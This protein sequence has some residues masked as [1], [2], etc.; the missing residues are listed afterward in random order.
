MERPA[1]PAIE[2][3]FAARQVRC[4]VTRGGRAWVHHRRT[5]S[6][7]AMVGRTA[8]AASCA[9]SARELA[10]R[11]RCASANPAAGVRRAVASATQRVRSFR[12]RTG[13]R[14]III[15]YTARALGNS[16]GGLNYL[17]D[18]GDLP[19]GGQRRP[20]CQFIQHVLRRCQPA[21]PGAASYFGH[22]GP[23]CCAWPEVA[24]VQPVR[25]AEQFIPNGHPRHP[26]QA[27]GAAPGRQAEYGTERPTAVD[28]LPAA[29]RQPYGIGFADRFA[30][31]QTCA[32]PAVSGDRI[33][34]H[35]SARL[36][37]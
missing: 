5:A 8:R 13:G 28:G 29:S 14:A 19:F 35:R 15:H 30:S 37:T 4:G 7:R 16:N 31:V 18:V 36:S 11:S 6:F 1:L 27:T 12:N 22:D 24:K 9:T 20:G 23:S 34:R 3:G 17:Q 21:G 10:R 33:R 2:V 32:D 26:G 25:D